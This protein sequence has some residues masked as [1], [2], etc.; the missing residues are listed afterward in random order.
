MCPFG[1]IQER[2]SDPDLQW[3]PGSSKPGLKHGAKTGK[4]RTLATMLPVYVHVIKRCRTVH[5]VLQQEK[6]IGYDVRYSYNELL[7]Q[8]WELALTRSLTRIIGSINWLDRSRDNAIKKY[9][10]VPTSTEKKVRP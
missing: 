10:Q 3:S 7:A 8:T 1:A 5:N 4:L 2:F 9:R 6:L